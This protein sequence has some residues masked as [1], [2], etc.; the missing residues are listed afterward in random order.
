LVNPPGEL[1]PIFALGV[2]VGEPGQNDAG[3][4]THSAL[5]V[6]HVAN[7]IGGVDFDRA[8]FRPAVTEL[9]H[10]GSAVAGADGDAAERPLQRFEQFLTEAS[11]GQNCG[12]GSQWE[13]GNAVEVGD[14]GKAEGGHEEIGAQPNPPQVFEDAHGRWFSHGGH[15]RGKFAR[16]PS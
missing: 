4:G 8:A 12:R 3:S 16:L 7:V 1:S 6:A 2:S 5:L 10:F 13:V 11:A 9:R 14:L 15:Y